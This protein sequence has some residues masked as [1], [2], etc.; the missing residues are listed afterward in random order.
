[1]TAG[2][3]LERWALRPG[4]HD[5]Y[6]VNPDTEYFVGDGRR[7]PLIHAPTCAPIGDP[8]SPGFDRITPAEMLAHWRIERAARSIADR[9]IAFC[10]L[11]MIER[12]DPP[13]PPTHTSNPQGMM[14]LS[15][16]DVAT[17]VCSTCEQPI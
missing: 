4:D 8:T 14:P 15:P 13:P 5:E 10:A 2:N 3:G 11:C 17:G 7:G 16:A 1:M 9:T 12:D 6:L